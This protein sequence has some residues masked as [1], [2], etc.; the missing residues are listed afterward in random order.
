MQYLLMFLLRV[1]II[2]LKMEDLKCA[3]FVMNTT[4]LTHAVPIK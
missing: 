2:I 4:N 3:I 1:K